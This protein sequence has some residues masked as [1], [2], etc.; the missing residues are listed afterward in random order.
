MIMLVPD[1]KTD[2]DYRQW[3]DQIGKPSE[4]GVHLQVGISYSDRPGP[5]HVLVEGVVGVPRPPEDD[6]ERSMVA[7][8]LA[9][10]IETPDIAIFQFSGVIWWRVVQGGPFEVKLTKSETLREL[11]ADE[12]S[13]RVNFS[14][15]GPFNAA[16]FRAEF[17]ESHDWER[18]YSNNRYL[19]F[20]SR[21]G[22]NRRY[23]D[24]LTNIT[25][26]ND[27]GKAD[28]TTEKHWHR[29]FRHVVVEMFLRG[30]PPVPH[31][32]DPDV[33]RAVLFPDTELCEKAADAIG[34]IKISEP[35]LVKYGKAEHILAFFE[36]GEVY[37]P[38]VS[39]YSD[40]E[41]NQAVRDDELS[42]SHYAVAAEA[43]GYLKSEDV[44]AN[45]DALR[46]SQDN[47]ISLFHAP[48]AERDEVTRIEAGM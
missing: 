43:G 2:D 42:F 35:V 3:S 15:P 41:H 28:L 32:F 48:H 31:N 34:N 14:E 16:V 21:A 36:R 24:L 22:L 6:F 18:E 12:V 10:L 47:L 25:I 7:Q 39:I 19:R 5:P 27:A 45:W 20:E 8:K 38:P 26:L 40:P 44:C 13:H 4:L 11:E 30:E 23:Q 46:K 1:N 33:E 17:P 9:D 29:L 37:M